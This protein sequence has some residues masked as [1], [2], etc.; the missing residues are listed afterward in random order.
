VPTDCLPCHST[1]LSQD[2]IMLH[3]EMHSLNA[4]TQV[5]LMNESDNKMGATGAA[6]VRTRLLAWFSPK[7]R[8]WLIRFI[9]LFCWTQELLEELW[10]TQTLFKRQNYPHELT[11]ENEMTVSKVWCTNST[12]PNQAPTTTD[13]N[14]NTLTPTQR[15]DKTANKWKM[16]CMREDLF[17]DE[18]ILWRAI[19][20]AR[21][22][23]IVVV[24]QNQT[25]FSHKQWN[26]WSHKDLLNWCTNFV[27][28]PRW[29]IP[30]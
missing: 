15:N 28:Y 16:F 10:G 23:V 22:L 20:K 24:D 11:F 14:K 17:R 30:T 13:N 29:H 4:H 8:N 26:Y 19:I 6:Y 9:L 18:R 21:P 5:H 3:E 25:V 1:S 7:G 12:T 27:A 2:I